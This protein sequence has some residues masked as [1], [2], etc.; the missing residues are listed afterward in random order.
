[1]YKARFPHTHTHTHTGS[2]TQCVLDT[3]T[4]MSK[5]VCDATTG[6]LLEPRNGGFCT[7]LYTIPAG[8]NITDGAPELLMIR[9]RLYMRLYYICVYIIYAF[10]LYMR[11]YYICVYIIYAF[12]L[13]MRLYTS[14]IGIL[15]FISVCV[16]LF[17]FVI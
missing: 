10:M 14:C 5:C 1:M 7:L 6:F 17:C 3:N 8:T 12:I 15:V 16:H 4:L 9:V 11:L 13:Y 2:N